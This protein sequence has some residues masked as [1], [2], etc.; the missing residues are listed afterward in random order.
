VWLDHRDA[1]GL[2][3]ALEATGPRWVQLP[4]AG[5][6]A[7]HAAGLFRWGPVFT[8]AK[9]A[10]ARPVAEHAL[11]LALAGLRM[12]PTR[13]AATSW[14]PQGGIPLYGSDVVVLG[15]G[16][17]TDELLRLLQPF[18][19]RATV[20]RRRPDPVDGAVATVTL[21]RLDEVLAGKRVVF[22][23]L[24][25]TDATRGVIGRAQLDAMDGDAW[26]VNVARGGH[27]VTDDLVAAL[28]A[29]S[30]GGA[31]LD[32]TDPEPL[33]DGH[34]LWGRHN[35]IITPHSAD[36]PAMVR[37]LLTARI[38]ANVAHFVAGEQLEGL[39]D[40]DAGY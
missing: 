22:L 31:G 19:V 18:D 37:P 5:V 20:V 14:G 36:T 25:L 15:A 10:Y 34:P 40:P 4:M 9:G 2:A 33:P 27:V 39:V 11:A 17:I 26:L 28:D 6:E 12:L 24:A 38:A 3:R 21:D 1:E 16:G 30:I 32:V 13:C 29:G 35:C 7:M 23:A 8:S